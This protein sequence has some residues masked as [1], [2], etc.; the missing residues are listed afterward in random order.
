MQ[1]IASVTIQPFIQTT[2]HDGWW[3]NN[4]FKIKVCW[5]TYSGSMT[6]ETNSFETT[7]I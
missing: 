2:S 3:M 5:R 4:F 7:I 1:S 6:T